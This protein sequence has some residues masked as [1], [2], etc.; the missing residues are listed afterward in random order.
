MLINSV[1]FDF[2][3]S[4]ISPQPLDLNLEFCAFGSDKVGFVPQSSDFVFEGLDLFPR[5]PDLVLVLI[6]Y[7]LTLSY[8]I[9][10][11][12]FSIPGIHQLHLQVT[13]QSVNFS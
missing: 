1:D 10:D 6:Q 13:Y 5:L 11:G 7:L 8:A 4:N 3:N 2:G 9:L 12:D